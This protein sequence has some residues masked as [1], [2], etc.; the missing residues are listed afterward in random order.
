MS[1]FLHVGLDLYTAEKYITLEI[2]EADYEA[3]KEF[4]RRNLEYDEEKFWRVSES[5]E[6]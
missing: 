5:K 6:D 2:S 1:R 3:L 4:E